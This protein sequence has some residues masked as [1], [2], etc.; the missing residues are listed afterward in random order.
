MTRAPAL[1]QL[2]GCTRD[3][4][5][6]RILTAVPREP[7]RRSRSLKPAAPVAALPAQRPFVEM[8]ATAIC[9]R[10]APTS[11]SA[12]SVCPFLSTT[13]E[14]AAHEKPIGRVLHDESLR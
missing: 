11:E 9:H 5:T 10:P 12:T 4:P 7:S 14:S 6:V 3:G 2:E 1:T 8:S 13:K